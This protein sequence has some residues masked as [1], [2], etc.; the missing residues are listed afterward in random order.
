MTPMFKTYVRGAASSPW[1]DLSF[2]VLYFPWLTVSKYSNLTVPCEYWL[3]YLFSSDNPT[4]TWVV[5]GP[6]LDNERL[7]QI[8]SVIW[9]RCLRTVADAANRVEAAANNS[10]HMQGLP[11]VNL[12]LAANQASWPIFLS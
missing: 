2:L 6:L 4:A 12:V 7:I 10:L 1:T 8:Q 5:W 11:D 9:G 3:L